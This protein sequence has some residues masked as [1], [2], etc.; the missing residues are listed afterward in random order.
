MDLDLL[1][2]AD[3]DGGAGVEGVG[4]GGLLG[5]RTRFAR[6]PGHALRPEE[7]LA[8]LGAAE[9]DVSGVLVGLAG[10]EVLQL[11]GG[12]R[13]RGGHRRGPR[14]TDLDRVGAVHREVQVRA[15]DGV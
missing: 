1:P 13:G 10:V 4:A 5:R 8:E 9:E 7:D 11:C 15:V 14:G 3:P 2:D 6:A 12:R